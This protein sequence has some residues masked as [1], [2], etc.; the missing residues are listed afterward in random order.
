M[1]KRRLA[2]ALSAWLFC[3]LLVPIAYAE[4]AI[5]FTDNIMP[6]LKDRPQ[7]KEFILQSFSVTDTGWGVRVDSLTMPHMGGARMGPYRFQAIWHSPQ[8]DTPVTLVI[9]TKTEFFDSHR[10]QITGSDL[11]RTTSITETLDCIEVEPPEA[12]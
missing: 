10:R 3:T 2:Q 8:G 4:G 7:F 1:A 12:Q 11:R 6:M 5:S 9:D